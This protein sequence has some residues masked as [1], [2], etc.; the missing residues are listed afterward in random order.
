MNR[1]WHTLFKEPFQDLR[2]KNENV[3]ISAN[4]ILYDL[5][6]FGLFFMGCVTLI[7]LLF[8][9]LGDNPATPGMDGLLVRFIERA[10]GGII[11]QS[12]GIFIFLLA[13]VFVSIFLTEVVNNTTV[14]LI[15]LPLS[16]QMSTSMGQ[17]PLLF[18]LAVT[19]A[20]SGAFMTPIATPVNAVSYASFPGVS[21]KRMLG[22]GFIL[23]IVAGAFF[24][25][26][27]FFLLNVIRF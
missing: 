25:F 6:F 17:N 18:L 7:A 4:R 21:L 3:F 8:L 14:L 24:S 10:A 19:L 5:P 1:V 26:L 12:G 11:P 9:K 15:M 27:I 13:V 16:V 2:Q 23:N 22:L 20:A